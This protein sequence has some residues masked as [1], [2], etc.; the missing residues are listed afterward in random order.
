MEWFK[1]YLLVPRKILCV[2]RGVKRKIFS[3]AIVVFLIFP[4]VSIAETITIV[5]DEWPP[6]NGKPQSNAE[7]YM[8]DVV[9]TVFNARGIEVIYQNVPWKRAIRGT[10]SGK[11]NAAIG[12]S[13][14]DG[15][16]LIFPEEELARN[17]L[18]FYVKKGNPWRFEGP[19]S[20]LV[21]CPSRP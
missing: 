9:R 2:R 12:A 1:L 13:K 17:V 4:I 3:T 19:R 5:A 16:G 14:N 20:Q 6:F 10:L 18:A 15:D 11:Y 7:G 8:V 21:W